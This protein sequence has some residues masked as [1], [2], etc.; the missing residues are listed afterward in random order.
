[1]FFFV[2]YYL[3]R[4]PD[5]MSCPV[6]RWDVTVK[7]NMYIKCYSQTDRSAKKDLVK[8]EKL[9][10]SYCLVSRLFSLSGTKA[11][12]QSLVKHLSLGKSVE[13]YISLKHAHDELFLFL[14]TS[15][16]HSSQLIG[17]RSPSVLLWNILVND[18]QLDYS[19]R[20]QK[21]IQIRFAVFRIR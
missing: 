1:M 18:F 15:I 4:P 17:G 5:C 20:P 13:S 7:F 3:L 8:Q 14:R 9:S 11:V 21:Q 16:H 19:Y 10:I 6:E 12:V 2:L